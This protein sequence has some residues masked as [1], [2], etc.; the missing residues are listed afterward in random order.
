MLDIIIQNSSI[1]IY[2][3]ILDTGTALIGYVTG[4][5]AIYVA[6][7]KYFSK[8][9]KL[10]ELGENLTDFYGDSIY[11]IIENA[12]LSTFSISIV[13]DLIAFSAVP[14]KVPYRLSA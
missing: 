14:F 11:C 13:S 9:I 10:I 6:W 5:I 7:L 2:Q 12:T 3:R 8:N 1:D 4:V